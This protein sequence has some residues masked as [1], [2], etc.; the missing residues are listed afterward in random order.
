MEQLYINN[1]YIITCIKRERHISTSYFKYYRSLARKV[2]SNKYVEDFFPLEISTFF[3]KCTWQR[4]LLVI[5]QVHS[6]KRYNGWTQPCMFRRIFRIFSGKLG[7]A[8]FACAFYFDMGW[9][10]AV[11]QR[12]NKTLKGILQKR[13][14]RQIHKKT[15]AVESYKCS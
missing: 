9:R 5:F 12:Q 10:E 6:W 11:A 3:S 14:F 15:P 1:Y 2:Y 7:V 13:N 8:A 4:A